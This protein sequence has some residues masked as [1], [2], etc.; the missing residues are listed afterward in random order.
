[1]PFLIMTRWLWLQITCARQV[2]DVTDFGAVPDGE[3]DNS[4]VFVAAWTKARAAPGRPAVVVPGGD[5]LLHPVVFRGPCRGYVEVR[6]AGVVLAPAG[7]DA[8]LGYHEW[9]NFTGIDG[10]LVTGGGT[11]DGR[12]ASLWHLNDCPIKPDCKPRPS[13]RCTAPATNI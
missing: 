10:L 13:V 2:F 3:T 9:I 5:Y 12:G 11:F 8:F 7:L 4:K 1:M 6:V